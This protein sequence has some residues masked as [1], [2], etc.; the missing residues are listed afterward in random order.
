MRH[1]TIKLEINFLFVETCET[2]IHDHNL[3]GIIHLWFYLINYACTLLIRLEPSV[4]VGSYSNFYTKPKILI[5]LE[6]D[7]FYVWI[8]IFK[9]KAQ[10]IKRDFYALS[11]SVEA[12]QLFVRWKCL[13]KQR[14][15]ECFSLLA[16][17]C[18]NRWVQY[19]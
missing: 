9:I 17:H 14:L 10:F 15:N 16:L 12:W 13:K 19:L 7:L 3:F 6:E 8:S 11:R 18:C 4:A 1:C 2:I 5:E